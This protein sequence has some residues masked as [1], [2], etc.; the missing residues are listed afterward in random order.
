MDTADD[1]I[2]PSKLNIQYGHSSFLG[3]GRFRQLD[4]HSN[5][6]DGRKI[7]KPE[8]IIRGGAEQK[9]RYS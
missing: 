8:T 2:T 1:P 6:T 4:K 3:H 9:T 5:G 7:W